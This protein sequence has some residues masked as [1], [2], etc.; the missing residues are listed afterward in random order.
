MTSEGISQIQLGELEQVVESVFSAMMDLETSECDLARVEFGKRLTAAVYLAGDWNGAVLLECNP[1]QA[2]RF[3]GRFLSIDPPT[4]VDDVVLDVLREL[5]NMIG[6]NLKCVLRRGVQLSIPSII[7]GSVGS[8]RAHGAE[9]C[10]RLAFRCA[11]G[12]FSISVIATPSW[13]DDL[14]CAICP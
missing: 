6:G 1:S 11:E 13:R 5:A 2:C 12:A 3:A 14:G 4:S 9:I 10:E 7:D 8:L